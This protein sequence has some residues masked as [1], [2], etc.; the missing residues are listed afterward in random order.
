MGNE[1]LLCLC[2]LYLGLALRGDGEDWWESI[3][4]ISPDRAGEGASS[5][6][7][8]RGVSRCWERGV[9]NTQCSLSADFQGV[10]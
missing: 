9:L 3:V 1:L 6:P 4:Y 2:M 8:S 7:Q 10:L 5:W